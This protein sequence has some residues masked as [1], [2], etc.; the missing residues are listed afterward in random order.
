V[1]ASI[2]STE[3]EALPGAVLSS[4]EALAAGNANPAA[5]VNAAVSMIVS[6]T[7]VITAG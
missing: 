2:R 1:S 4:V 5:S 7:W 6:R 3:P